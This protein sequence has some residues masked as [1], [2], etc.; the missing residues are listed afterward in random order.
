MPLVVFLSLFCLFAEATPTNTESD[1][2]EKKGQLFRALLDKE[3]SPDLTQMKES[4]RDSHREKMKRLA[5]GKN[6]PRPSQ[7]TYQPPSG[8]KLAELDMIRNAQD[9]K[10]EQKEEIQRLFRESRAKEAAFRSELG[11]LLSAKPRDP[12]KIEALGQRQIETMISSLEKTA[13]VIR[14]SGLDRDYAYRAFLREHR[15]R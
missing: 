2:R 13:A 14:G 15:R 9:L 8:A 4:L 5:E 12:A 3:G 6:S 1:W 7:L 11:K 10:K